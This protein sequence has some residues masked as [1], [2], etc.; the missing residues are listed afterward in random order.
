MNVVLVLLAFIFLVLIAKTGHVELFFALLLALNVL[1]EEQ[2]IALARELGKLY[3]YLKT[4]TLKGL[5]LG[6]EVSPLRLIQEKLAEVGK[7]RAEKVKT[8]AQRYKGI[9][10]AL[11]KL[12]EEK[13]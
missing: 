13:G 1:P 3:Y 11:Q 5:G 8:N 6:R 9:D 12:L 2:V 10:Q 7:W 4:M